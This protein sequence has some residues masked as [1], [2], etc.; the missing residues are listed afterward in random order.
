MRTTVVCIIIIAEDALYC[1]TELTMKI[2][3]NAQQQSEGR[4]NQNNSE[5]ICI[6]GQTTQHLLGGVVQTTD[7]FSTHCCQCRNL[8]W[9]SRQ[10]AVDADTSRHYTQQ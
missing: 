10:T 3:N 1:C 4:V 5:D 6:S 2:N 9:L 8:P 7:L